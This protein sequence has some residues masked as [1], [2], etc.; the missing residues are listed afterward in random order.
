MRLLVR[1]VERRI[2]RLTRRGHDE[3]AV[4]QRNQV[5]DEFFNR[6]VAGPKRRLEA[7]RAFLELQPDGRRLARLRQPGGDGLGGCGPLARQQRPRREQRGHPAGEAKQVA[8]VIA[9]A[10][11]LFA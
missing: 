4:V 3:F 10:A 5:E 1:G 11:E 6:G 7:A 9:R 8:T 2:G